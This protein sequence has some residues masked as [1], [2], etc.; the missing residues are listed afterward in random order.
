MLE[1]L[2]G[3]RTAEK[4][5]LYLQNYEE[6]YGKAIAD[7]NSIPLNAVQNQLRKLEEGGV[8]VSQLKGRT[9]VYSW[10]PRYPFLKNLRTLL[11]QAFEYLPEREIKTVYR[12]RIRPRR[13]GK[14]L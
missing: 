12:K 2:F 10:N 11:E 9:R 14:P 5:L 13:T 3:N 6:G 4:V 7:A 1:S 8:I